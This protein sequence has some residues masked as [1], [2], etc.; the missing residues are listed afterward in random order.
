MINSDPSKAAD[1]LDKWAAGLEQRARRYNELQQHLDR[2]TAAEST[3]DGAVRV[4]V[5]SNGVPTR[6]DLSERIQDLPPAKLSDEIMSCMRRAQ[7]KL[8]DQVEELVHATVPD[9]DQPARNIVA[10][11]QQRFPDPV[12]TADPDPEPDDGLGTIEDDSPPPPP[13]PGPPPRRL[14][15]NPHPDD[16]WTD[17][18]PLR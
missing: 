6:L 8:R 4:T 2:T 5:D 17:E 7:A 14:A 11:Y 13:P 3:Q 9:D 1:D 18:S 16:D 10:Q 15:E 12:D